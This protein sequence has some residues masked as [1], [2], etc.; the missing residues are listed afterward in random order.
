MTTGFRLY[1]AENIRC[2]TTFVFVISPRFPSRF[3]RRGGTDIGVQRDWLLVQ[4]DHRFLRIVG[5][6]V[7]LQHIFH[8]GDVVFIEVGHHPHFFP[9]TA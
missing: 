7:H 6:F 1:G 2:A 9:A 8:L 3:R 5:L 4:A